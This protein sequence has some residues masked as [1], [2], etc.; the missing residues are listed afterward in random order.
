[1]GAVT[2]GVEEEYQLLDAVTGELRP[3]N[4]AVLRRAEAAMGDTVHPELLQSQVEVSTGVCESLDDLE[5]ELRRLRRTL[6]AAAASKGC[7]LG[8]AGTHPTA[9]W[10]AQEVTPKERYE[11]LIEG[12]QQVARETLIF[13]CHVHIGVADPDE[14]IRVMNRVRTCLPALL[15]LSANSPFWGGRDTGYAS[16]RTALFRRWPMTGVPLPFA[17]DREYRGLVASLVQAGMIDDATKIYWD[18][19]PSERFP[20][21]EFRVADVC[22]SVDEAVT[23]AGLAAGAVASAVGA[24]SKSTAGA[25]SAPDRRP[26][27]HPRPELLE[28]AVWHAARYGLGADLIDIDEGRP[29]PASAT[30]RRTLDGLRDAL[31]DLGMWDRVG[32][33]VEA[34][35]A[36]GNG[37]DR[38]RRAFESAGFPGVLELIAAETASAD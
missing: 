7:R 9:R 17:D 28:A 33:G 11:D 10:Q 26:E 3:D 32:E 12:F 27:P 5:A 22:L 13:G 29:A 35:L 16:Y 8:A 2:I 31:E 30:I 36:R 21:L 4:I 38:Q 34:I 6:N 19:R 15:A 37:A 20:T 1:V 24:R 18:I 23:I 14:R 25:A